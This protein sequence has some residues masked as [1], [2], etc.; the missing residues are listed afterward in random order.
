LPHIARGLNVNWD[1][2]MRYAGLH[3]GR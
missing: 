2:A 3:N 1:E